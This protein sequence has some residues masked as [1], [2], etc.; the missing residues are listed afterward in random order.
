[1][2]QSA[3]VPE[4]FLYTTTVAWVRLVA[5]RQMDGADESFDLWISRHP[6][7]L[8]ATFLARYYSQATLQSEAARA[9]WIEPDLRPLAE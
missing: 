6:E 7:L 3:G 2:A 4:K 5:A 8:D 1:M 9:A